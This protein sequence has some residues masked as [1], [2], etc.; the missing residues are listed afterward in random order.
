MSDT[1][2]ESRTLRY[3]RALDERT[4]RMERAMAR[5]FEVLNA[6][7]GAVETRMLSLETRMTALEEWSAETTHR[8]DRIERRLNLVETP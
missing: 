2:P 7:M 6:R 8:L 1:G 4:E 5:A 3:L